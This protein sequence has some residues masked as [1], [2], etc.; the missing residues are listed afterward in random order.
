[1]DTGTWNPIRMTTFQGQLVKCHSNKK[2]M[3]N[4]HNQLNAIFIFIIFTEAK[5]VWKGGGGW[6]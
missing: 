5:G 4:G 2:N 1:M 3:K 6:G